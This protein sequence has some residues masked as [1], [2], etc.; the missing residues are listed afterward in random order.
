M[1]TMAGVLLQY[2]VSAACVPKWGR[3][4]VGPQSTQA[5]LWAGLRHEH[6]ATFCTTRAA[7]PYRHVHP[8]W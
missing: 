7:T 5:L 3:Q 6:Q 8:R 2:R 4:T 1:G